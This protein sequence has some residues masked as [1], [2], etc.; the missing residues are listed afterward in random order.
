MHELFIERNYSYEYHVIA[1]FLNVSFNNATSR[2]EA[3]I[4]SFALLQRESE[5]H[6]TLTGVA[7]E[8][9]RNSA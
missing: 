3:C 2:S 1:G 8:R 6:V 4:L 5:L 9:S 7:N